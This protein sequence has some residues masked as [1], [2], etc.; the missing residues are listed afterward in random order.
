[1]YTLT[2]STDAMARL[3]TRRR[4]ILLGSLIVLA[5]STVELVGLVLNHTVG[6]EIY[7]VLVAVLSVIAAAASLAVIWSDRRR[8]ITMALLLVLWAIVTLGGVA[9]TYYHIVGVAPEY[10]PV[11]PRPRPAGAPL[12][13]IALGL[14]GGAALVQAQRIAKPQKEA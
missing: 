12:V 3:V 4:V 10:G 8:P 14:A 11:D 13:Y 6:P 9:G 1:M 2:Q 5:W 7:G